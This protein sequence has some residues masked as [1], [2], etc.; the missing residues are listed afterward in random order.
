MRACVHAH[1]LR[2]IVLRQCMLWSLYYVGFVKQSYLGFFFLGVYRLIL[3]LSAG[4]QT[5]PF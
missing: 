3:H 5:Q 2:G 1:H 4:S